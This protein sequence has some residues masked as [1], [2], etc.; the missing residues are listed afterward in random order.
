[1]TRQPP[2]EGPGTADKRE[3]ALGIWRVAKTG[4]GCAVTYSPPAPSIRVTQNG[5]SRRHIEPATPP[6]RDDDLDA[7]LPVPESWPRVFPGL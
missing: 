3:G 2:A 7:V 4:L 1:M 6:S 5:V